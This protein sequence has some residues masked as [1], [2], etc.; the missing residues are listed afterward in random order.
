M[1]LNRD[2]TRSAPKT[3]RSLARS[4]KKHRKGRGASG[5]AEAHVTRFSQRTLAEC[6]HFFCS[7]RAEIPEFFAKFSQ[8]FGTK[9]ASFRRRA[10]AL[11]DL[12]AQ[13]IK[14][15]ASETPYGLRSARWLKKSQILCAWRAEI[16]E[17][18]QFLHES[19]AQIMRD[20]DAGRLL[21]RIR[22]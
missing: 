4:K 1:R 18:L 3:L 13:L 15:R 17:I 10:P 11:S 7:S 19:F 21:I 20:L 9:F 6:K 14:L 2:R 5:R 22:T 8:E 16:P 12:N